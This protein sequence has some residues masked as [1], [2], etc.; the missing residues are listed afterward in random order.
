L[1]IV[2]GSKTATLMLLGSHVTGD[3]AVSNDGA[4]GTFVKF[5]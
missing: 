1:K 5:V 3:F 2:D 4:G